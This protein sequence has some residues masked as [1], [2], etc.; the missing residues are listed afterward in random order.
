MSTV[1]TPIIKLQCFDCSKFFHPRELLKIGDAILRC[2]DCVQ[3]FN[4]ILDTWANPPMECA[5]CHIPYERCELSP[6]GGMFLHL[7]DGV[8]GFLC[9]PCDK[10]YVL[11]RKDL[12][13]KTPFGWDR[14]VI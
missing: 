5:V 1:A 9:R 4:R 13:G 3:K 7:I 8:M 11:K 12:Y 2:Y 14:K 10:N 6:E